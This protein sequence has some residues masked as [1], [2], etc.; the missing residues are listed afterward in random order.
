MYVSSNVCSKT[1]FWERFLEAQTPSKKTS[2]QAATN[3]VDSHKYG[4]AWALVWGLE[5]KLRLVYVSSNFVRTRSLDDQRSGKK[6]FNE[7]ATNAVRYHEHSD[8]LALVRCPLG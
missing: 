2:H 7:T 8:A 6:A 1:G 4:D 5:G 3:A